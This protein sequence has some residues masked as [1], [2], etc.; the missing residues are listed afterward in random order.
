MP[1]A[2]VILTEHERFV[3]NYSAPVGLQWSY[4][5]YS[6][7][8]LA[9]SSSDARLNTGNFFTSSP[10]VRSLPA[11]ASATQDVSTHM[12]LRGMYVHGVAWYRFESQYSVPSLHNSS[13]A[14]I[15]CGLIQGQG[16]ADPT[17]W[18]LLAPRGV[19]FV[20]QDSNGDGLMQNNEFMAFPANYWDGVWSADV[21]GQ[22][23]LW[24]ASENAFLRYYSSSI[25]PTTGCVTYNFSQ[26]LVNLTQNLPPFITMERA[27]YS[28]TLDALVVTGFTQDESNPARTWGQAGRYAGRYDAFLS[29]LKGTGGPPPAALGWEIPWDNK[30]CTGVCAVDD[31]KAAAWI[32][33][34]LAVVTS[35]TATV[36]L[37]NVTTG[38]T[39]GT[40]DVA[41]GGAAMGN[42]TGWVDTPYGITISRAAGGSLDPPGSSQRTYV[43]LVEED[44]REKVV[45]YTVTLAA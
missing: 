42:Y 4:V 8:A 12:W 24:L 43:V 3:W 16:P 27:M 44:G 10:V 14:A 18:P 21:D 17:A 34:V 31:S 5:G 41:A 32:D 23:G 9:Y 13:E 33:D 15:P 30:T 29:T 26:P 1:G 22:G 45:V 36:H 11:P 40:M 28:T 2:D 37:F 39:L 7:D 20:W 25:N 38:A 35:S 19:P 6:V